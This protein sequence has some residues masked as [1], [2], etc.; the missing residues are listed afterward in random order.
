MQQKILFY[1]I[2]LFLVIFTCGI[3]VYAFGYDLYDTHGHRVGFC[4]CK[5]RSACVLYDKGGNKITNPAARF[6]SGT[7]FFNRDALPIA[8]CTST[9]VNLY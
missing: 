9:G 1:I 7:V 4:R 5:S 8:E 2:V 6:G 3:E